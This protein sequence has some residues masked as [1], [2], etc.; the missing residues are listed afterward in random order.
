MKAT[1]LWFETCIF[2]LPGF[3]VRNSGAA[4]RRATLTTSARGHAGRKTLA[5]IVKP[6]VKNSRHRLAPR[7]IASP[8][9]WAARPLSACASREARHSG[10]SF[11]RVQRRSAAV[12]RGCAF[13]HAVVGRPG[14]RSRFRWHSAILSRA[15]G[16]RQERRQ[17]LQAQSSRENRLLS[18]AEVASSSSRMNK[19]SCWVCAFSRLR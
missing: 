18:L 17:L 9:F 6:C 11:H 1:R 14:H 5:R 3:W 2:N 4:V 19:N 15:D 16:Q 10:R 8:G 13:R 12:S 7:S